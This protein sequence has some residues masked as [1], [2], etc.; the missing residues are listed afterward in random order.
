MCPT[1]RIHARTHASTHQG[2]EQREGEAEC[3]SERDEV[4]ELQLRVPREGTETN[5]RKGQQRLDHQRRLYTW[6]W[7]SIL[8]R[9]PF[10]DS[11]QGIGHI[12][13]ETEARASSLQGKHPDNTSTLVLT[14]IFKIKSRP[15][16]D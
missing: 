15:R 6:S 10:R 14:L 8:K 1:V 7:T 16:P 2:V 4:T 12:I 9:K 13:L 5:M 3:Y 11:T